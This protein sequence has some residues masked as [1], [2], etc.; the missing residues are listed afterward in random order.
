VIRWS[1]VVFAF[2]FILTSGPE[3]AADSGLFIIEPYI[4]G[5]G[6]FGGRQNLEFK[7]GTSAVTDLSYGTG[8]AG[9]RLSYFQNGIWGGVDANYYPSTSVTTTKRTGYTWTWNSKDIKEES[10]RVSRSHLGMTLGYRHIALI[11]GSYFPLGQLK[12]RHQ[13]ERDIFQTEDD[14]RG[15]GFGGGIGYTIFPHV[16]VAAEYRHFEYRDNGTAASTDPQGMEYN[17]VTDE[18]LLELTFPVA[19]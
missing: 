6:N 18:V 13:S 9:L 4:G 11:W 7:N 10:Y 19:F 15:S 17:F 8:L 2:Q 16:I 5:G 12:V 14:L 1:L 3:A